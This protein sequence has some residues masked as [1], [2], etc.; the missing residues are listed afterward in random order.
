MRDI[1]KYIMLNNRCLCLNKDMILTI[2]DNYKPSLKITKNSFDKVKDISFIIDDDI[3]NF[4]KQH[5]FLGYYNDIPIYPEICNY[6]S[7]EKQKDKKYDMLSFDIDNIKIDEYILIDNTKC[8]SGQRLYIIDNEKAIHNVGYSYYEIDEILGYS[9]LL[10][11]EMIR[12][13]HTHSYDTTLTYYRGIPIELQIVTIKKPQQNVT[14]YRYEEIKFTSLKCDESKY[15]SKTNKYV[16]SYKR[17][18]KDSNYYATQKTIHRKVNLSQEKYNLYKDI[19]DN[20]IPGKYIYKMVFNGI[21]YIPYKYIVIED[22]S[23]GENY[24]CRDNGKDILFNINNLEHKGF[25]LDDEVFWSDSKVFFMCRYEQYLETK[26]KNI[27]AKIDL[28]NS[29]ISDEEFKKLKIEF[30]ATANQYFALDNLWRQL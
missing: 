9:F 14:T 17:S 13:I 2:I 11:K 4:Y 16:I 29:K 7:Y 28:K 27:L 30:I 21:I 15:D 5:G 19:V 1:D 24:K 10:T 12:K 26:L 3:I 22:A 23:N 20:D 8:Y 6:V 18:Q 25:R